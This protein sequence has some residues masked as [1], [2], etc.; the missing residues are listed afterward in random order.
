MNLIKLLKQIL[1]I[2]KCKI[3]KINSNS[4]PHAEIT[5]T[6]QNSGCAL[7]RFQSSPTE[8]QRTGEAGTGTD[9]L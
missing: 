4:N 7:T 5:W 2:S 9:S 8:G 1:M 6:G 3:T